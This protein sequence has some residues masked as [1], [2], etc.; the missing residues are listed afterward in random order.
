[1]VTHP[2]SVNMAQNTIVLI[3]GPAVREHSIASQNLIPKMMSSWLDFENEL[4]KREVGTVLYRCVTW[5]WR[6]A[7]RE[8]NIAGCTLDSHRQKCSSWKVN[9]W[10]LL[11]LHACFYLISDDYGI[12]TSVKTSI[13]TTSNN[14]NNSMIA[15][16]ACIKVEALVTTEIPS[17]AS[18][19]CVARPTSGLW[20]FARSTYNSCSAS[21]E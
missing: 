5:E 10:K 14:S 8:G 3:D 6:G 11:K 1:M 13:T 16:T 19:P 20:C 21:P 7:R 4:L 15:Q 2:S 17:V 18:S 12:I 9:G